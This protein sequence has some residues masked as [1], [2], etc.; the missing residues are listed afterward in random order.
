MQL[1]SPD[2]LE[3]D[4]SDWTKLACVVEAVTGRQSLLSSLHP[5]PTLPVEN[6]ENCRKVLS[7]LKE[8][9]P[10]WPRSIVDI[11]ASDICELKL[12]LILDFLWSL[13]LCYQIEQDEQSEAAKATNETKSTLLL[14]CQSALSPL[15]LHPKDFN[16]SWMDGIC[17]GGLVNVLKPEACLCLDHPESKKENLEVAFLKANQ[18]LSIPQLLD[19]EDFIL[20]ESDEHSVMTYVSYF[21]HYWMTE[22]QVQNEKKDDKS[23]LAQIA[24]TKGNNDGHI[25]KLIE[26]R[27]LKLKKIYEDKRI[28]EAKLQD[29]EEQL[30]SAWTE[31]RFREHERKILNDLHAVE[32][33]LE[34]HSAQLLSLEALMNTKEKEYKRLQEEKKSIDTKFNDYK[35]SAG[36][37]LSK[38]RSDYDMQERRHQRQLLEEQNKAHKDIQLQVQ[39]WF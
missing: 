11:E 34:Q 6:L 23:S 26:K 9:A 19:S 15:G 38:I 28:L 16:E 21:R 22:N 13:I 20:G 31:Q 1:V 12:D 5:N 30:K 10:R 18:L 7:F 33:D 3:E 39:P 2:R 14:W 37:K 8:V 24:S 32:Q 25:L 17:F 4:F 27:F 36:E 29:M 35:R